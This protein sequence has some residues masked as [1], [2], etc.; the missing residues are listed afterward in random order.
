VCLWE[1]SPCGASD[2]PLQRTP[3]LRTRFDDHRSLG[4]T[5]RSMRVSG[6]VRR[7]RSGPTR[8][9]EGVC[10]RKARRARRNEALIKPREEIEQSELKRRSDQGRH[11]ADGEWVIVQFSRILRALG[12]FAVNLPTDLKRGQ[13]PSVDFRDWLGSKPEIHKPNLL[14]LFFRGALRQSAARSTAA[15]RPMDVIISPAA[16]RPVPRGLHAPARG[17]RWTYSEHPPAPR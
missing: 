11:P 16:V 10:H 1:H 5:L 2:P 15:S 12:V 14:I 3:A 8:S 4:K 6:R 17:R 7:D 13:H 9:S